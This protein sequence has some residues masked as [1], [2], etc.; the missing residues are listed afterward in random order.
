MKKREWRNLVGFTRD[1]V[2]MNQAAQLRFVCYEALSGKCFFRGFD[3]PMT[4]ENGMCNAVE[5]LLRHMAALAVIG[6]LPCWR[7]MHRRA[8]PLPF[9]PSKALLPVVFARCGVGWKCG[10]W[11]VRQLSRPL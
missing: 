4:G 1:S 11:Q 10:S 3:N 6:G 8:Q 5:R 7:A 2:Q 9:I